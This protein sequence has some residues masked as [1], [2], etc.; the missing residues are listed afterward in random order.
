VPG[1][2]RFITPAGR[3]LPTPILRAKSIRTRVCTRQTP[4]LSYV[5]V[6]IGRWP[7]PTKSSTQRAGFAPI[8]ADA[9]AGFGGTLNAFEIMK[10]FI[11]AGA[12]G[13]HFEDLSLQ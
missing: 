2:T 13:V 12:A 9:E 10:A 4:A 7:A 1:L 5:A 6:S 11:G 8:V 3:L